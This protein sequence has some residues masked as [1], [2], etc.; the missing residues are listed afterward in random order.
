MTFINAYEDT[1]RAETYSKL[2]FPGT[3]YLAYRDIPEI[4]Q[5]HVNGNLALDFGCGTGRSTRFL[6]DLGFQTLGID[7][8]EE[9]L[10]KAEEQDAQSEYLLVPNGDLSNLEDKMFDLVLSVFTFDNIPGD[11]KLSLF[12][13]LSQRLNQDGCIV[14]LISSPEI[15]THEWA[16]F[17]TKDFPENRHAKAGDRVKIIITDTE[18]SRPVEDIIWP[19]EFYRKVY[20][21]A[22]LDVVKVYK[23]LAYDHEPYP[24]VNETHIPPWVIYVLKKRPASNLEMPWH[25]LM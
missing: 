20:N 1:F 6:N 15:Y 18:D 25:P 8:S 5:T 12:N 10:Q 23:P 4:V 9:M 19:D 16:S 11:H 13:Q 14:N 24:W 22:G 17:S 3:Y 7:I 2:E 21:K